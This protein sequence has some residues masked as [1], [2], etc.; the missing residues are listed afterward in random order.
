MWMVFVQQILRFPALIPCV[1]GLSKVWFIQQTWDSVSIVVSVCCQYKTIPVITVLNKT[2]FGWLGMCWI[3]IR[4]CVW[5]GWGWGWG[6]GYILINKNIESKCLCGWILYEN[7]SDIIF[8][9]W[10]KDLWWNKNFMRQA[11]SS[12]LRLRNINW[13]D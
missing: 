1:M 2:C 12:L 11:C 3:Y 8:L 4:V 5:G 7:S 6:W 13:K 10:T 9:M